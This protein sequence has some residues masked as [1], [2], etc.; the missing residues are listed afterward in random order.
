MPLLNI[1]LTSLSLYC[2]V[3]RMSERLQFF[4]QLWLSYRGCQSGDYCLIAAGAVVMMG[5]KIPAR[6][7]VAGVPGEIR[8]ELRDEQLMW[9]EGHDTFRAELIRKLKNQGAIT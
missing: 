6:S 2:K 4:D 9:V 1:D 8:G 3:A 5:A 7:F